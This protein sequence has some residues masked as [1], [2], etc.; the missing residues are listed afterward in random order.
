MVM[1]GGGEDGLA[2]QLSLVGQTEVQGGRCQQPDAGVT[3]FV[4]VPRKETLTESA[5]VLNRAEA[6]G[7]SGTVLH[8]A[9]LAFRIRIVV[10]DVWAG[11]RLGDAEIGEQKG[12]WF[13]GHRRAR[14]AWRVS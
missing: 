3:V 4:V 2:L 9:E 7:K 8:G 6:V 14:S 11:M 13:G 5:T 1:V 12:D 10:G